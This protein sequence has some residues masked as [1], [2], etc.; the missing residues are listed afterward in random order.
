[1]PQSN[2]S[3]ITLVI[4]VLGA[5]LGIYNT[6][7][8][9]KRDNV[10]VKLRPKVVTQKNGDNWLAVD[11]INLSVFPVT[12]TGISLTF[13]GG[14]ESVSF[15]NLGVELPKRLES[16]AMLSATFPA[17]ASQLPDFHRIVGIHAETACGFRFSC[18]QKHFRPLIELITKEAG[19][20]L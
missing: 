14:K 7:R 9:T 1:M 6:W 13:R 10:C 18:S 15:S 4:A 16:R 20:H 2:S 5:L 17:P 8:A 12:I 11:L 3:S 19:N